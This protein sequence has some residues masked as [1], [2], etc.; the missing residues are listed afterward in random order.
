MRYVC[1]AAAVCGILA[2]APRFA[3]GQGQSQ[4]LAITNYRLVSEQRISQSQ[5]YISY[6]ADLINTGP[7]RNAVTATVSSH[8]PA[9]Q[10]VV[11]Q[12]N[13]HF[14]PV[15]AGATVHSLDTFT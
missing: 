13:L 5:S 7:A 3:L 10:V 2:F 8:V 6:R 11:G 14:A 15:P 9:V 1:L 4:G 12:A